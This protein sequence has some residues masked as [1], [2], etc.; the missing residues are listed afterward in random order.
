MRGK[1]KRHFLATSRVE[2]PLREVKLTEAQVRQ[3]QD[4]PDCPVNLKGVII[5]S[6]SSAAVSSVVASVSS[7]SGSS[8]P[9][10]VLKDKSGAISVASDAPGADKPAPV[11]SD[12]P[13][14]RPNM[15]SLVDQAL[16]VNL[17]SATGPRPVGEKPKTTGPVVLQSMLKNAFEKKGLRKG[18]AASPES[19][20]SDDFSPVPPARV[21][22]P[23]PLL[24][25][26]VPPAPAP[27]PAPA[28]PALVLA[29]RPLRKIAVPSS[30]LVSEVSGEQN[31][32]AFTQVVLKP[33][34]PVAPAVVPTV[35]SASP[36]APAVVPTV[37][38]ASP[39][40]PAVVPTV[41]SASPARRLTKGS[42]S[43]TELMD[44]NDF[45]PASRQRGG[46]Y[47][48]AIAMGG[49][50]VPG[51]GTKQTSRLLEPV[52]APKPGACCCQ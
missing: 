18:V 49:D 46:S 10:T 36:V 14:A 33:V 1:F 22:E 9:E 37:V 4:L 11:A 42:G 12:A 6:V 23:R 20:D 50:T 13:P 44:V 21:L 47:S 43:D 16:K 52:D 24:K 38:S 31:K 48:N 27:T 32:P 15:M 39:V 19:S 7:D 26:A 45:L 3:L 8:S 17:K 34:K 5:A 29:P 30:R 51:A 25:I 41:V 28:A 40:A 35:V 2:V